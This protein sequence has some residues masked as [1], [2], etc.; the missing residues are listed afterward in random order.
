MQE[1]L[2][3]YLLNLWGMP[4]NIVEAVAFY[5]QPSERE[6]DGFD[7][8]GAVHVANYLAEICMTGHA[9][10]FALSTLDE[11][12]LERVG[13]AGKMENWLQVALETAEECGLENLI[14]ESLK[15]A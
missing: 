14:Q 15:A 10:D 2:G 5:K 4:F 7:I 1:E 12:Y 3:A 9:D 11:A 8:V 6:Y 13:Q